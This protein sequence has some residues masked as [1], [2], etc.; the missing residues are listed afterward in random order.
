MIRIKHGPFD[1]ALLDSAQYGEA[2]PLIHMIPEETVRAAQDLRAKIH[3]PVHWGKFALS[4]HPWDESI[5]RL[6]LAAE[7]AE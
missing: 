3:M 4:Y 2:W 5:R 6:V 7:K 1:L